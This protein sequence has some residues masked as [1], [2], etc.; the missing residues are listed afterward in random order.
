MN[1]DDTSKYPLY[2]SDVHLIA[3]KMCLNRASDYIEVSI[4]Y[5]LSNI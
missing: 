1:R 2:Y 4:T 5:K 3:L